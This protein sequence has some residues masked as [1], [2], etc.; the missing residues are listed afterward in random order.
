MPMN[1]VQWIFTINLSNNCRKYFYFHFTDKNTETMVTSNNF[2]KFT[3]Q[4]PDIIEKRKC[5]WL[6]FI[7]LQYI[8]L[9][10]VEDTQLK[11]YFLDLG[12]VL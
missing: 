11:S 8:L 1:D 2:A 10:S 3:E 6:Q 12:I 9:Q 5:I 4:E 7:Y